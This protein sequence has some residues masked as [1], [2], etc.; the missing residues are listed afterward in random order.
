[1]RVTRTFSAATGVYEVT[2]IAAPDEG[3]PPRDDYVRVRNSIVRWR[4]APAEGGGTALTYAVRTDVGGRAPIWIVRAAQRD[5]ATR[6]VR[7][8]L[9]RAQAARRP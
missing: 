3:P 2:S 1:V 6:F 5:A 9:D 7:A 4:L 8:M